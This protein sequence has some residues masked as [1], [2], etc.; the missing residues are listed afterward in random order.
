MKRGGSVVETKNKKFIARITDDEGKRSSLGTFKTRQEAQSCIDVWR[1]EARAGR[2][3]VTKKILVK[4]YVTVVLQRRSHIRSAKSERTNHKNHIAKSSIAYLHVQSVRRKDALAFARALP[5]RLSYTTKKHILLLIRKAFDHAVDDEIVKANPFHGVKPPPDR[6]PRDRWAFWPIEEQRQYL[7]CD[8]VP[9]EMRLLAAIAMGTGMRLRELWS[10]RT[11]DIVM[12]GPKPHIVV[13]YGSRHET[14]KS[15]KSR[16]IQ[17]TPLARTALERWFEL[18]PSLCLF[19]PKEL[20]FPTKTGAFRDKPPKGWRASH[21]VAGVTSIRW[22]D[23]R[24]TCA[25]SLISGVWGVRWPIE[26]VR[27][28]LGHSSIVLTQRY[29]HL[30]PNFV[31][32][33]NAALSFTGSDVLKNGSEVSK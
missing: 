7:A 23:L 6:D 19:N 22:H 16:R 13:R 1:K 25:S 27:D 30:A 15:G 33:L 18:L 4:D 9:E 32:S 3:A 31:D 29:A 12:D 2:I 11:R 21:E 8:K 24:H 17:I 10:L 14:T 20:A 5:A 26:A 28:F